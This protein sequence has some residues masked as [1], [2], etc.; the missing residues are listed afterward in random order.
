[1]HYQATTGATSRKIN[2]DLAIDKTVNQGGDSGLARV[3]ESIELLQTDEG[4][5]G[6]SVV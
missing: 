4:R 5:G 3:W 2:I 6:R 1:M